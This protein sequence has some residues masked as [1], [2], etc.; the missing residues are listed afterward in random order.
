M[1]GFAGRGPAL[2]HLSIPPASKSCKKVAQ[3][4]IAPLSSH[5]EGLSPAEKQTGFGKGY[6]V[7]NSWLLSL[8]SQLPVSVLDY[9]EGKNQQNVL[10]EKQYVI[11]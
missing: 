2:R 7:N 6:Q 10:F 4:Y 3:A 1:V 9:E 8:P 11:V 5:G